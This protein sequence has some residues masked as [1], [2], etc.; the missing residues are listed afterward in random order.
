MFRR[1]PI[2]QTCVIAFCLG[3]GSAAPEGTHPGQQQ[4]AAE[5]IAAAT[6]ELHRR[7][8]RDISR[9]LGKEVEL[10]P[11]GEETE[12]DKNYRWFRPDP[13]PKGADQMSLEFE[14]GFGPIQ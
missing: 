4:Q 3:G 8:V 14:G 11:E 2:R 13:E 12:R 1:S 10:K 7:L 9:K 6:A 5:S